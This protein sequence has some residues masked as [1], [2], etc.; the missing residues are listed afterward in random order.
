MSQRAAVGRRAGA[1]H[2]P[3]H[4]N[5][6]HQTVIFLLFLHQTATEQQGLRSS[7]GAHR[8]CSI[9]WPV[10]SAAAQQRYAWPP[11]PKSSD[12]PPKA[13]CRAREQ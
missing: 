7:S 6:P 9:A 12:W 8:V 10:R 2:H 4:H 13:R 1:T 11:R 5:F 3:H